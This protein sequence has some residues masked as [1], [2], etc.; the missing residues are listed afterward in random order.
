MQ[1]LYDI[2]VRYWNVVIPTYKTIKEVLVQD[3]MSKYAARFRREDDQLSYEP[4]Q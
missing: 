1:D 2:V 4:A 3:I